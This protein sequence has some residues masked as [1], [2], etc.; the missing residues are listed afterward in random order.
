MERESSTQ[1]VRRVPAPHGGNLSR[2]EFEARKS[3]DLLS[4]EGFLSDFHYPIKNR[5][6]LLN[7]IRDAG[8]F[9]FRGRRIEAGDIIG[10]LPDDIFPIKSAHD[11][12]RHLEP[13]LKDL[14]T[15]GKKAPAQ[16]TPHND[17]S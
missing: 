11:F 9:Y 12:T 14:S 5:Q 3:V 13:H 17:R 4:I 2:E 10:R 1:K 6:Q 15:G 8:P 7:H 16:L